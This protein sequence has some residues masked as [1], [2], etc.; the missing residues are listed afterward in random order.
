MGE[1]TEKALNSEGL[2]PTAA[3]L[4]SPPRRKLVKPVMIIMH[5]LINAEVTKQA[6]RLLDS[7]LGLYRS[8]S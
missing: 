4:Q 6:T 8:Y 2:E 5:F 1:E 7:L 3:M